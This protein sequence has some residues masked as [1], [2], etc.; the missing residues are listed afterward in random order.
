MVKVSVYSSKGIRKGTTTLPQSLVE[1]DNLYLLAQAIRVYDQHLYPIRGKT[2]TRGEVRSSTA[3]IWRQ[4]GTGRA[5]HGSVSA[6]IF[7]GGGVAHGP[8][9][10]RSK[11]TLP[12]KIRQKALKI[13]LALKAKEGKLVVAEGLKNIKK[14]KEAQKLVDSIL[15]KQL[16]GKSSRFTIVLSKE[17]TSVA[18]FFRNLKNSRVV[19][20]DSL[21]ARSVF[22]GGLLVLDKD[23]L[24]AKGFKKGSKRAV[25]RQE[26]PLLKTKKVLAKQEVSEKSLKT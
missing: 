20:F 14:T 12:Q 5:R 3:K 18:S 4:K 19:D 2:K 13:S 15:E 24:D 26:V 22:F 1:K 17:N 9:G 10:V 23:A 11:L 16:G 6:P 25:V 21:N 7:V 8:A